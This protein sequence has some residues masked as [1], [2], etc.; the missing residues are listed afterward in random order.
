MKDLDE[1]FY[2]ALMADEALKEA[3]GGR[4]AST[5][6]EV[7]PEDQDNTPLPYIVVYNDGF[8]NADGT[9]DDVWEGGDDNVQASVEI[10]A[11]SRNDVG[12]LQLMARRAIDRYIRQMYSE[13]EEVPELL[14]EYPRSNGIEWNWTK[15]CYFTTLTYQCDIPN[16]LHDE[17]D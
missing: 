8:F 9:K 10:N 13:C 1:I 4:I 2:D 6:F 15:P 11:E 5:G 3:V 17:Q 14:P 16:H 7:A 12:R